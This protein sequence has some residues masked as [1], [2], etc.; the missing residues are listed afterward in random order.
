MGVGVGVGVGVGLGDTDA[1]DDGCAVALGW[2]LGTDDPGLALAWQLGD[3]DAWCVTGA[4]AETGWDGGGVG[5]A[6][7]WPPA[8][9]GCPL[10]GCELWLLGD[11]AV[12]TSIAT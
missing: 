12:E 11:T 9:P 10:C 2:Q 4:V 5:E 7:G 1:E 3:G 6:V 8:G